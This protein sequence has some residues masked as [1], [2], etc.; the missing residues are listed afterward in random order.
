VKKSTN[1]V[2]TYTVE[3]D[4]PVTWEPSIAF[5]RYTIGALLVC[6]SAFTFV[7]LLVAPDQLLVRVLG[8]I[9]M[10]IMALVGW[11]FLASGRPR[12]C[13]NVLAYGVWSCAT[14]IALFNGGVRATVIVT[15]PVIILMIGWMIRARA[16]WF[17]AIMTVA[18]TLFFVMAESWGFLPTPPGTHPAMYAAVQITI[19]I[20]SAHL[21]ATLLRAYLGQLKD[22][23]RFGRT[24][25]K[26]TRELEAN[27]SELHNA[28][29]VAAVG[30]WVFEIASGTMTLSAEAR[31]IFNLSENERETRDS[32]A[33]R[34]HD[35]DREALENAW[36]SALHGTSVDH[37][38]RVIIGS[39]VR[40]VRQKVE[41]ERPQKGVPAR[42]VGI[43][44]DVTD[45]RHAEE[46]LR[47]QKEF[48]HLI[49]ESMGDFIAVVDLQGRRLYNSPSYLKFFGAGSDLTGTDSFSQIHPE[50]RERVKQVFV[51][52]V[53]SGV[54]RQIH[55]RFI[56]AN[57]TVHE[58]ESLGSVIRDEEGRVTRV[59][60]VSRDITERRRMEDQ[61]RHLAFYDALTHLPN[62]RL[63]NDRLSQAMASSARSGLYGALMFLDLDNFKPLNDTHGHAVGDL[64]LI[65]AARRLK[66]CVREMDTVARFGG[67]E[68]VLMLSE[69]G[70]DKEQS[71]AEAALI[72]EK[73]GQ[74]LMQPY[75][76]T[77]AHEGH[78]ALNIEHYCTAS[79]GVAL[80]I[81]HEASQG[82]ILKWADRAMYQ[83]KDAGR[84][85]V[86]FFDPA[87]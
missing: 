60:V 27:R 70:G 46:A 66:A 67:D 58:V 87:G 29:A 82:D 17:T 68:F 15:Y 50:D 86:C 79:I 1:P 56:H 77:L 43:V 2:R 48:F 36:Q 80:F 18:M 22:L 19:F 64:L 74:A 4:N 73:V 52:T 84:N 16:A 28:Q 38:H 47:Q 23:Q 41:L 59:V 26:Q 37:E 40:W 32:Y 51:E 34:V 57:G 42:I 62:R 78:S 7:T 44:Q 53:Q 25:T 3:I 65:E 9:A 11:F 5:L 69:L 33:E 8:P 31:R 63:L 49:A 10:W 35:Q 76:L 85:T 54:G 21:I 55:Y 30:S 75:L 14:V 13:V 61:L 83:A 71:R 20:V 6:A 72:A 24:L 81:D 45:R 12:A 39:Q